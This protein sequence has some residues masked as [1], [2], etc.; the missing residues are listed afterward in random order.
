MQRSRLPDHSCPASDYLFTTVSR[1]VKSDIMLAYDMIWTAHRHD[2]HRKRDYEPLCSRPPWC[3]LGSGTILSDIS[4]TFKNTFSSRDR[5]L[6]AS[7][8][9][10]SCSAFCKKE[11]FD[12]DRYGLSFRNTI[13]ILMVSVLELMSEYLLSR[14]LSNLCLPLT[15]N[16]D[17]EVMVLSALLA[18]LFFVF[19]QE[20]GVC[21]KLWDG[22][23]LCTE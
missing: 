22:S 10:Q 12:F 20:H 11:I 6:Y 15:A 3:T 14:A 18:I 2:V 8:K 9:V 23:L 16:N 13:L 5:H 17:S 19:L 7:A 1:G 4:W 21:G